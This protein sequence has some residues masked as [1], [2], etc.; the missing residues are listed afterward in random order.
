VDKIVVINGVLCFL[1]LLWPKFFTMHR[2]KKQFLVAAIDIDNSFYYVVGQ[3][4]TG[5]IILSKKCAP[6]NAERFSLKLARQIRGKLK[7]QLKGLIYIDSVQILAF[8][9][10]T[11]TDLD[12]VEVKKKPWKK[13]NKK[14]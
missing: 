7:D 1:S 9:V 4:I 11:A 3:T 14:K 8:D 12:I 5:Q 13:T 6:I 2:E 10:V